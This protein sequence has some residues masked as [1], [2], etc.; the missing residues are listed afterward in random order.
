MWHFE[1]AIAFLREHEKKVSPLAHLALMG[2]CLYKPGERKDLDILVYPHDAESQYT[3]EIIVD[4]LGIK[5]NYYGPASK[6]TTRKV[7]ICRY[8]NDRIDLFFM[9]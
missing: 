4:L 3:H 2:G 1:K 9:Q 6:E 8:G 5:L 7:A